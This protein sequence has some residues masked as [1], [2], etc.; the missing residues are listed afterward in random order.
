MSQAR[1]F[2][3]VSNYN[4][5]KRAN[6]E[7]RRLT[8]IKS[9][10]PDAHSFENFP[11]IFAA[12][13]AGAS[14]K[15]IREW[16]DFQTP[17]DLTRRVCDYLAESGLS[18]RIVIEPSYGVG[19]FIFAALR[20]LPSVELVYGVEIQEKYEW[21]FKVAMLIEALLGRHHNAQIDLQRGSIFTHR[22]PSEILEAEDI[23]IVGNPP[24][25]T[26]AEL[27]SLTSNNLPEKQNIKALNGLDAMT[28]K[29]NF[30]V[31]EYVLLKM[32]ELLAGRR[33]CLAMLCKNSVIKNIME[34][35]PK[36][37]AGISEVRQLEIDAKREFGVSVD[38]SLL[39]LT[40]GARYVRANTCRVFS[41]N[42]PDHMTRTFG[43]TKNKF[44]SDVE[45]YEACSY[46]DGESPLV[47]R[48][49]LKHDCAQIMELEARGGAAV[50]GE[51]ESIDVEDERLY[52]LLK[53]S[54]LRGV[55]AA[56][57]RKKVIVTQYRLGEDTASLRQSAPKLWAYLNNKKAHFEKRKSRIYRDRPRFSIFGI[58]EYA[59]KP[60]KVATSGLYKEP[61]F[62]LVEPVD[63][64]PVMLDDTCYFL[65]FEA[66]EDALFTALLLNSVLVK[67]FLQSIVF[68]DAKRPYTKEALMRINLT[69]AASRI[70]LK[71][72][73]AVCSGA[74]YTPNVELSE[75][76]FEQYRQRLGERPAGLPFGVCQ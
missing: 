2:D 16:G 48:Q 51:G 59:F 46:L 73:R 17:P 70:S 11:K 57:A 9:F 52:W 42:R 29:S 61:C 65:G 27:G 32:I 31:G 53:S 25:V 38:A 24:W 1:L 6:E 26:S 67:T 55:A 44:V 40:T 30:D 7:L 4:D 63:G 12:L 28:G 14:P 66:Y 68:M 35:M 75:K 20:R 39:V 34:S 10:F 41:F 60:Y 37:R 5:V 22:F 18:P 74:G 76:S 49:G 3:L 21:Q 47:W 64:R 19:N 13:D 71:E 8:G 36:S 33:G 15:N 62:T 54:D 45:A 43:W 69:K 56:G 72:L 23:L 58:G 50:N